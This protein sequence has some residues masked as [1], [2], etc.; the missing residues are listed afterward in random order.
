MAKQRFNVEVFIPGADGTLGW[1]EI[2]ESVL[3]TKKAARAAAETVAV[4]GLPQVCTFRPVLAARVVQWSGDVIAVKIA[5]LAQRRA[6][7]AV[8][9]EVRRSLAA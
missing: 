6:A 1:H 8:N 2:G 7:R 4:R 9:A 5:P 3:P